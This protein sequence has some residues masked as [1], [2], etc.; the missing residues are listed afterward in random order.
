[1]YVT[2]YNRCD[3]VVWTPIDMVVTSIER[4]ETFINSMI[5]SCDTIYRDSIL[6]ELVTRQLEHK[7]N[8]IKT[9]SAIVNPSSSLDDSDRY[10]I[11]VPYKD[12]IDMIQCSKCD[13]YFHLQ[14]IKKRKRKA[15][16]WVCPSCENKC[17]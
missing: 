6:P 14:C 13:K 12:S 10:C 16:D 17:L 9:N 8:M 1:M 15:A 2:G 3:F 4:D 7:L 11:C 5:A